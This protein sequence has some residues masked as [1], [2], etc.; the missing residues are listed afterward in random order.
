[1]SRS[2]LPTKSPGGKPSPNEKLRRGGFHAETYRRKPVMAPGAYSTNRVLREQ[3]GIKL[4][5]QR[6][7]TRYTRRASSI[8]STP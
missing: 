5:V 4:G 8:E 2:R 6:H 7:S 3:L 1:M